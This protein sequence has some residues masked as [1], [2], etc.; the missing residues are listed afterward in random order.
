[1]TGNAQCTVKSCG[2]GLLY[3][4]FVVSFHQPSKNLS[5]F[6]SLP[7]CASRGEDLNLEILLIGPN[8]MEAIQQPFFA[9]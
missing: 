7:L 1:M 8:Q 2:A 9:E 5:L 4:S 3:R 6:I